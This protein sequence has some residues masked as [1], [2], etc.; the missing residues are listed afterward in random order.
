[1]FPTPKNTAFST[2]T[3]GSIMASVSKGEYRYGFNGME[4]DNE[5][6]GEGNSLDFGARVYDSR[7]GRWMSV[8]PLANH[9]K[10]IAYSPYIFAVNSPNMIVDKDGNIWWVV[11]GALTGGTIDAVIGIVKGEDISQIGYRFVRGATIGAAV[12]GLPIGLGTLGVTGA[13]S[14]QATIYATPIIYASAEGLGQTTRYILSGGKRNYSMEDFSTNLVYSLSE[15]ILDLLTAGLG[16]EYLTKTIK[17]TI[18]DK[19]IS[20]G[21]NKSIE[22]EIKKILKSN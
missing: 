10:N 11:V 15:T 4:K 21:L 16:G 12:T 19:I 18:T 9:E 3:F 6:K 8:D 22:R 13:A 2:Y 17:E 1:M 20:D 5:L 14:I 7:L